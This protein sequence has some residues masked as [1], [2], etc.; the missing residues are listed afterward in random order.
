M[1]AEKEK[2]LVRPPTDV[3][4]GK[5]AF[6][7]VAEVPGVGPEDLD[8]RVDKGLLLLDAKRE[9]RVAYA[10]TFRLP[11]GVDENAI[12]ATLKDGLVSIRLP[13]AESAKPRLVPIATG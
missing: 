12:A 7:L 4:E 2:L 5:D 13:K 10:R 9:G 11:K 8:V 3:L 1:S 6:V